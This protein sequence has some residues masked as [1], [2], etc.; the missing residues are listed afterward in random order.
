MVMLKLQGRLLLGFERDPNLL[1]QLYG[2]RSH[3]F[4]VEKKID[5]PHSGQ[6]PLGNPR[7]RNLKRL[8][9]CGRSGTFRDLKTLFESLVF[10]AARKNET[11]LL[12]MR[13]GRKVLPIDHHVYRAR[14]ADLE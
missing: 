8:G 11:Y 7:S 9:G 3:W 13:P 12:R 2:L 5:L 14:S 6:S 1:R 10:V 4:S